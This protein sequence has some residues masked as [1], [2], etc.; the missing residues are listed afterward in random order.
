MWQCLDTSTWRWNIV[1]NKTLRFIFQVW[2]MAR[3]HHLA[4]GNVS[5][6]CWLKSDPGGEV[7]GKVWH[8]RALHVMFLVMNCWPTIDD[9][10]HKPWMKLTGRWKVVGESNGPNRL[11]YPQRHLIKF[12]NMNPSLQAGGK[13]CDFNFSREEEHW[14][15]LLKWPSHTRM[16]IHIFIQKLTIFLNCCVFKG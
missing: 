13:Y 6:W 3:S 14:L 5:N 10:L 7:L 11:L 9:E 16:V 8:T 1:D 15:Q 12:L 4:K 2:Y